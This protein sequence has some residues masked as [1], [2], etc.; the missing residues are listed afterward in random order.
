[1]KR[2]IKP[3]VTV[4]EIETSANLMQAS[5]DIDNGGTHDRPEDRAKGGRYTFDIWN[6]DE[7]ED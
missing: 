3:E 7:E 1:M 5:L 4:I 2:Y 6:L